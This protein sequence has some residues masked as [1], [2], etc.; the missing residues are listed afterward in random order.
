M[1]ATS[2]QPAIDAYFD[3]RRGFW[4]DIYGAEDVYS[5]IHQQR[6][7]IALGW[8]DGL[9]LPA[10]APVLDAGSGAGFATMALAQRGLLVRATDS[11]EGMVE[12][13]R[14]NAGGAGLADRVSAQR[15]DVQSLPF[16]D[17]SF[18]LALALGVLPWVPSAAIAVA[19]LSRV[20]RRGGHVIVNVDNAARLTRL[21]DPKSNPR[22]EPVKRRVKRLLG[23]QAADGV[24][25]NWHS[26][27]ELDAIIARAGLEKV[28]GR[29]FG[30]GPFSVLGRPVLGDQAAIAVHRR[31]Q[32]LADRQVPGL[33]TT[34]AQYIVLARRRA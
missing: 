14:R 2:T 20:V 30:F 27:R 24:D 31:L 11:A 19:E 32:A 3:A 34:G 21:L 13:T 28:H 22:M 9:G 16:D 4:T 33:A 23:R 18:D 17:E 1:N 5:V 10:G 26:R 6:L 25:A 29:A 7:S 12:A 8:I 15:G